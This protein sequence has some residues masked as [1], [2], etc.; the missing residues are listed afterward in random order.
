MILTS[1]VTERS[2]GNDSCMIKDSFKLHKEE[3]E[4]SMFGFGSHNG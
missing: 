2:P 4:W 1:P 3:K